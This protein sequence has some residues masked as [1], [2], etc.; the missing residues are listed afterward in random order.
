[1]RRS[2]LKAKLLDL[3]F[4]SPVVAWFSL[5]VYGS[6]QMMG[7]SEGLLVNVSLAANIVL[8]C[9]I[10]LAIL[11]RPPSLRTAK[12]VLPKLAGAAGFLLPSFIVAVPAVDLSPST[13]AVSVGLVLLGT[14]VSIAATIWLGRSFSIL[15]QARALVTEGP[16]RLVR[17]PLYAGELLAL[18]GIMFRYQQPWALCLTLLSIAIQFP[19]MNFEERVLAEAFPSYKEYAGRTARLIPGVY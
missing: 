11:L 17:H 4:A 14:L 19:R 12:G 10:M 3:I 15:P 9:L 7:S 18:I 13:K 2:Y 6:S 8:L 5:G 1:M 16:Y